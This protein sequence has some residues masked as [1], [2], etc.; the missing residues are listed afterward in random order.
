MSRKSGSFFFKKPQ[1]QIGTELRIFK[2]LKASNRQDKH[3]IYRIIGTGIST[4]LMGQKTIKS[5]TSARGR[6]H[7]QRNWMTCHQR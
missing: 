3:T 7:D 5:I 2:K 1:V 6:R 4:D